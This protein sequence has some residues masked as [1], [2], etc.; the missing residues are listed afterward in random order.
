MSGW[1]YAEIFFRGRV[2]DRSTV[3][4]LVALTPTGALRVEISARLLTGFPAAKRRG[5]A[6]RAF[7]ARLKLEGPRTADEL[8][9]FASKE[10][11]SVRLGVVRELQG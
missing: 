11:N 2:G 6:V 10:S 7:V 4:G 5:A 3:V 8:R 1:F 9:A